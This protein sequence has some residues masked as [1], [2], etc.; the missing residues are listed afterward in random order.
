MGTACFPQ[1]IKI[2][3]KCKMQIVGK[4]NKYALRSKMQH[5]CNI[6]ATYVHI[7]RSHPAAA[8]RRRDGIF[9]KCTYVAFMLHLCCIF[10]RNAFLLH[11]PT[12][13]LLHFLFSGKQAMLIGLD[14][15]RFE[16]FP[17][18]LHWS[19]ITSLAFMNRAT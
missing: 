9:I 10:E 8:S 13:C 11:F 3:Q 15:L 2:Q 14:T 5:K 19:C 4:C 6:N 18:T 17:G 1:I 12:I 7:G 16:S